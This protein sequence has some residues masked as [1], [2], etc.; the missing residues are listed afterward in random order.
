MNSIQP[1]CWWR[2]TGV[3]QLSLLL[4]WMLTGD[5]PAAAPP[6]V[7]PEP[8]LP[9]GA[10]ARLG[11]THFAMGDKAQSI[12]WSPDGST[13]AT[14]EYIT[15]HLR[16]WDAATGRLLITYPHRSDPD[17]GALLFSPD[18]RYLVCPSVRAGSADVLE[19]RTR[20]VHFQMPTR[21]DQDTL[22]FSPDGKMLYLLSEKELQAHDMA[23]LRKQTLLRF[24]E[25]A[26]VL[27]TA[28]DNLLAI[29]HEDGICLMKMPECKLLRH[30]PC[31]DEDHL[32][33]GLALDPEGKWVA[34]LLSDRNRPIV[35][36]HSV[37]TIQ[38]PVRLARLPSQQIQSQ[39]TTLMRLVPSPCGKQLAVVTGEGMVTLYDP[40]TGKRTHHFTSVPVPDDSGTN[41]F[42]FSPD[43]REVA[44]TN[45]SQLCIC[46]TADGKPRS[47]TGHRGW[48]NGL[49]GR[50]GHLD[51]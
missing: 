46:S 9:A 5:S 19:W 32:G 21:A 42:A 24:E 18:G 38:K 29:A 4:A 47:V 35:D 37:T 7:P 39:A 6:F 1:A 3:A 51:G 41:A 28:G 49:V 22:A 16:F 8:P 31:P 10:V 17:P 36:L 45:T 43:A 40:L 11:S 26:Y 2:K 14:L 27:A 48:I 20:R 25:R 44:L 13:I 50:Q 12:A 23:T 34:L 33:C 15:Q 30:I